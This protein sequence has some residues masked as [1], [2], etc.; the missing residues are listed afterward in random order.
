MIYKGISGFFDNLVERNGNSCSLR[1]RNLNKSYCDASD[2]ITIAS[3][4]CTRPLNLKKYKWISTKLS[5]NQ[6]LPG[7]RTE[8]RRLNGEYKKY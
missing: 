8:K 4:R 2:F 6:R 5:K 3:T 7:L 1:S